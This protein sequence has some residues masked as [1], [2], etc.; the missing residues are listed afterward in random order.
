LVLIYNKELG[1]VLMELRLLKIFLLTKKGSNKPL[2]VNNIIELVEEAIKLILDKRFLE[3]FRDVIIPLES[4][5]AIL[6]KLKL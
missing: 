2:L 3:T 5:Q 1:V 6:F 4:K